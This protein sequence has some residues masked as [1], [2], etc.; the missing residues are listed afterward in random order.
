MPAKVKRAKLKSKAVRLS[1]G[2]HKLLLAAAERDGR[3]VS[4]VADR[5][6]REALD[7]HP[8]VP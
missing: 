3:T 7:R 5:I 2:A 4:E 1:E 8:I 6:V